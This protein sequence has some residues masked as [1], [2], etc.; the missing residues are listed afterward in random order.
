M[1]R[2]N[3]PAVTMSKEDDMTDIQ[4]A[5]VTGLDMR[6]VG[7]MMAR[8]PAIA[9]SLRHKSVKGTLT[10]VHALPGDLEGQFV[11]DFLTLPLDALLDKWYGGRLHAAEL[12]AGVMDSVLQELRR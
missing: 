8:L 1:R 4:D 6:R 2:S 7:E 10:Y 3:S 9:A 12:S 5:P 11:R